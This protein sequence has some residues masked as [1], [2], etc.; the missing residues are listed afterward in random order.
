MFRDRLF[1]AKKI[2]VTGGGTGLGKG[3][4]EKFLQLGA[5]IAICGRRKAVCDATAEALM[6]AHGG[7]VS[8]YG[9]DIRDAAAVDAMVEDIFRERPADRPRQQR[10]RQFHL[11]HRGSVAARL[12][13]DRQ[14]RDARDVLCHAG[15]RQALDRQQTTRRR[16][17]HRGDMGAQRRPVRRPLGDEQIGDPGDDDVARQ[18]MG[19][20][21]HPPQRDRAGRNSDRRH[22]QAPFAGRRTRAPRRK[23]S[24]RRGASAA[25]R[26]CRIW[27]RFCCPTAAIGF[28]AK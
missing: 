22:E 14:Y 16:R 12:R 27:R 26:N 13:R 9:V 6:K 24:T 5:E 20:L 25:S 15:R 17:L 8:S 18:R 10:R 4:A 28:R 11:A 7:K 2:L 3:M 1:E 23:P 19:P 21:R